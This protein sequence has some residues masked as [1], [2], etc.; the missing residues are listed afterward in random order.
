MMA[1]RVI[2]T[3]LPDQQVQ[4]FY[5]K[6]FADKALQNE[7]WHLVA[8]GKTTVL[9]PDSIMSIFKNTPTA[10]QSKTYAIYWISCPTNGDWD[11]RGW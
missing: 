7:E 4:D 6:K 9:T 11:F 5:D 8:M 3:P 1:Y 10:Q 2:Q